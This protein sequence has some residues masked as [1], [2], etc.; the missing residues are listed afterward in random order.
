MGWQTIGG[1]AKFDHA[2]TGW[3]LQG[4]HAHHRLPRCHKTT[5]KQ[6][7]RTYL[8]TDRTC[9]SCHNKDQPH[10]NAPPD[11][12]ALR[13]LPLR[14][15]VDAA[16]ADARLRSRRQGP[17]RDEARGLARRRRVREVPPEGGVQA[18]RLRQRRVLAV[19]QEPARRPAVR[20]RRS[21]RP[22]TRRRCAR[23]SEVRF[24]HKK[25][26]GYALVGKHAA[27]AV[28]EL[29]HEG[30]RQAQADAARARPAT[31]RTTSTARGST[32]SAAHRRARP[33][34]RSARGSPASSSTTR[35]TPA[36]I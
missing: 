13:S 23:C 16:E 14:V 5:N 35:P 33:A 21:A 32:R 25:Q 4:K 8:G 17:G 12:H 11:A 24:D 31:P 29:P 34:T 9:G 7:L 27:I 1:A 2:Q 22:A 10:G 26:T 18:P 28:R 20:R 6:G 30:A 36:S 19:P 15:G 3:A